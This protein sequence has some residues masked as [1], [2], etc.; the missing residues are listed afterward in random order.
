[1]LCF[2]TENP[3]VTKFKLL[4]V[5][6]NYE[7]GHCRNPSDQTA[8]GNVRQRCRVINGGRSNVHDE[9]LSSRSSSVNDYLVHIVE[10]EICERT[11]I[12]ISE[13]SSELRRISRT[14][15]FEIIA[16]R[17]GYQNFRAI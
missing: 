16:V 11:L 2:A 4:C 1:M 17:L 8:E 13:L 14:V 10:T 15:I 9:E 3:P 12:R 7:H 5:F 6:S